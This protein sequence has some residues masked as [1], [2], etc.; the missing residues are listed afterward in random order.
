ML[1]KQLHS[2]QGACFA[3]ELQMHSACSPGRFQLPKSQAE[4]E[5]EADRL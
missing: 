3:K 1:T 5:L 4:A 2:V